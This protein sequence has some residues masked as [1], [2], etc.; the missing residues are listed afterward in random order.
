MAQAVRAIQTADK[1]NIIRVD[2]MARVTVF[3]GGVGIFDERNRMIGWIETSNE[4]QSDLTSDLLLEI[5]NNPRRAKQPD[6]SFLKEDTAASAPTV[7]SARTAVMPTRQNSGNN[8]SGAGNS[9]TA[10]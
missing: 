3:D 7:A 5:I 10:T 8:N 2:Q 6:W 4:T 1:S 9:S